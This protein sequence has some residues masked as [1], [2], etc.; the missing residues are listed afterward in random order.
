M[1]IVKLLCKNDSSDAKDN[2]R[3]I[4]KNNAIEKMTL[5]VNYTKSFTF[6]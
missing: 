5:E 6:S 3:T 2:V 1:A 4:L